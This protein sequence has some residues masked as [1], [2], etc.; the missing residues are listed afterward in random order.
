MNIGVSIKPVSRATDGV[1]RSEKTPG[2]HFAVGRNMGECMKST[3][4]VL[5]RA[6]LTGLDIDRERGPPRPPE[7]KMIQESSS[8][9]KK[10]VDKESEIG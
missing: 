1:L 7:S 9:I 6:S 3:Q 8:R 2:K 5:E 4:T 10:P